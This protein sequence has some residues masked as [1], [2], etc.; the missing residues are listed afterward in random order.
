M[1]VDPKEEYGG[2]LIGEVL[3]RQ[4]VQFLY[5][6]CGGHISPILIG[7]E[8]QGVRIIDVRHEATAVFAADATARLTGVTGVAAVTAGAGPDQYN[9]RHQKRSNGPIPCGDFRRRGCHNFKR[10]G[11]ASGHRP[12][13]TCQ[14]DCE[15]VGFQPKKSKSLFPCSKKRLRWRKQ[16]CP[17]LY[18]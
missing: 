10:A 16:A 18:F 3:A 14:T 13:F 9:H 8:K 12:A 6:L 4:G 5:T 11:C 1:K 7:A 15:M 2:T 17:D